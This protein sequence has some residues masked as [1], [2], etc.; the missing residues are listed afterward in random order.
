M[1][2]QK[3][4]L[5]KKRKVYLKN[6]SIDS[7][8][9]YS[10]EYYNWMNS[11]IKDYN[12]ILEIGCGNGL[13][14]ISL[15]ENG[16]RVIAIDENVECLKETKRLL[17]S[18]NF[19]VRL[20]KRE[21]LFKEIGNYYEYS[22]SKI[23]TT[24]EENEVLLIEGDILKDDNL[25]EWLRNINV[26]CII[27]WLIGSHAAR[28]Y[29]KV[30]IDEKINTPQEYRLIVQNR[31]YEMADRILKAGKALHIVDRGRNPENENEREAFWESHKEQA[32]V[33][34][35]KVINISI[36]A[37]QHNISRGTQMSR[38]S[39]GDVVVYDSLEKKDTAFIS[40]LSIKMINE[41]I[42]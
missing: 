40:A 4:N 20:I 34:C 5:T 35:L 1:K 16:H 25:E 18:K 39:E 31:L 22:L 27:C 37:Y 14:T 42:R 15:L 17:E 28:R 9:F 38:E 41:I 3:E 13:S 11:L 7:N 32:S 23:K 36:K 8:Y 6:W 26:D 12:L 10:N 29:N 24:F 33:T 21:L 2:K 30:V 19:K